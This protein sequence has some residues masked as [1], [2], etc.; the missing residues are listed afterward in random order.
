MIAT[1]WYMTLQDILK[2]HGITELRDF[3]ERAGIAS[4]QQAWSLWHVTGCKF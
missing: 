4:R 2:K 3:T 1:M